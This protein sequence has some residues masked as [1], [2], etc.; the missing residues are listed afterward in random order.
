[1]SER[2]DYG[3]MT[4]RLRRD[5]VLLAGALLI[6]VQTVL[7]AA[8]AFPSYYWHDDFRHLELARSLGLSQGY[9][10]R[11]YGGHLEVGQYLVY[12]LI[13]RDGGLSF[14]SAALSLVVMQL[15]ASC[16][17][18]AVL[19]ELF[20]RSPWLLLPFAGYLF[21][22][23]SLVVATWWAAGMQ[24]LPMQIAM[25]LTIL[26]L[27][28][29]VRRRSWRWA[30]VSVLA[31]G[32]GLLFWEKALLVLPAA[33]AVLVLVEWAGQPLRSRLRLLVGSWW[34]LVP[35][36]V[37]VVGYLAVYLA[38]TR[39]TAVVGGGGG[40]QD[41][42]RHTSDT[43]F[44]LLLPGIFGGPWTNVGA[45]NTAYPYV[46]DP[47]AV[48]FALVFAA[49]VAASVW[50]RG[51]RALQAWG[52]VVGYVAVDLALL[53]LGR[54]DFI[55]I[56]TRDPRYVTDALP[57]LAI[58]FCAAFTGPAVERRRPRWLPR[59]AAP[60]TAAPVA[61]AV[62]TAS[63]LLSTA[64]LAGQLQHEFSRNYVHGVVSALEQNPDVAV[65]STPVPVQT[66]VSTDMA[67]MLRAVGVERALDQPGTDVRMF[68][69]IAAL[70]PVA[71]I[72]PSLQAAGPVDGCGWQVDGTWQELGTLPS[73]PGHAQVLRVGYM[74]GQDATLHLA[75][76]DHEQA[77][78]LTPG[79][80][81]ATFVVTGQAGPVRVRVDDVVFGGICAM[82]VI[83]GTPWPAG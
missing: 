73:P 2:V 51:H 48:L 7:R 32:L 19:R 65:L 37:V 62:L 82:D 23:L 64:L 14:S 55:G 28:R 8:V 40:P 49:V 54:A 39:S 41:V 25:L 63:C 83:A 11:D 58:G 34:V 80:G 53:Q 27:V 5:P 12:W 10:V 78:A 74:T 3:S 44:R 21:S 81:R 77:L 57:V 59:G 76:G 13:G 36:L 46:A 16:L 24:A 17:L 26:A 50:L 69:G 1:M 35:H 22:P 42:A 30:A 31:N 6:A 60:R 67:G 70:R 61:V 15:I 68:D 75:V 29:A 79:V 43:V 38:V 47:M 18:L 71:V 72:E 33:L 9:L 56:L 45:E 52:L 4:V 20:G 66:T